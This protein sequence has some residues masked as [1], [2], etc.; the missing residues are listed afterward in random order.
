MPTPLVSV[1]IPAF[2]HEKYVAS[3]IESVLGQ[4][5]DDF[6]LIITDDASADRTVDVIRSFHDPRIRLFEM[7]RN[8]GPSCAANNNIAQARGR[9]LAFLASDDMFTPD[10][11]E[12][13]FQFLEE[14]AQVGAV[15]SWMTY[16][17]ESGLDFDLPRSTEAIDIANRSQ[18]EWLRYLFFDGN[19]FS[20]P[21]AMVR[22]DLLDEKEPVDPRLL[23]LQDFDLWVRLCLRTEMHILPERLLKYRIRDHGANTSANSPEQQARVFWEYTK[24]FDHF[25]QAPPALFDMAFHNDV[26]E[27]ARHL[28]RD[29]QLALIALCSKHPFI[30]AFGLDLAH[31]LL[32]NPS[33]AEPML[34]AGYD[35]P[36]LFR[37]AADVDPFRVVPIS[38]LTQQVENWQREYNSVAAAHAAVHADLQ[39]QLRL[40]P[41]GQAR[42]LL[43][44]MARLI[45]PK[46]KANK[47]RD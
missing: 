31:S 13:Q 5:L 23:Q 26:P 8:L 29:I 40:S 38:W 45:A 11:L 36:W 43:S 28:H 35:Y 15:F 34:A 33:L 44:K 4:T 30:R 46:D 47:V 42:L 12:K 25:R 39:A 1:C 7:P 37:M 16:V 21:T 9:Y 14:N 27:A 20:A 32:G 41:L 24:V 22:R 2:N 18:A 17:S 3:A 6:E 10:K 19:P